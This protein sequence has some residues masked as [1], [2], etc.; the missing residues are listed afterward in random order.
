MLGLIFLIIVVGVLLYFVNLYV[1]MEPRIKSLLNIVVI[2]LL[3]LYVLDA[4]GAFD[5][6][7]SLPVPHLGR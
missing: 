3:V 4:I 7:R 2:L 6:L 1:P 5:S